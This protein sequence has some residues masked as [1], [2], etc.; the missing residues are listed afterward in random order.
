MIVSE[1]RTR[2]SAVGSHTEKGLRVKDVQSVRRDDAVL[3]EVRFGHAA[4][5]GSSFVVRFSLSDGELLSDDEA[6]DAETSS[7]V[8]TV[9]WANMVEIAALPDDYLSRE[10]VGDGDVEVIA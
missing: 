5:L 1:L 2:L 8:T 9:I 4:R 10:V 3:I 7:S 6:W